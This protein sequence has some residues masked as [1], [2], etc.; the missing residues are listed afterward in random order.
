MTVGDYIF[1]SV[2]FGIT[3]LAIIAVL[4]NDK[5]PFVNC[6]AVTV[7]RLHAHY[8]FGKTFYFNHKEG[9]EVIRRALESKGYKLSYG[10]TEVRLA[11]MKKPPKLGAFKHEKEYVVQSFFG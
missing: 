4:F 3:F 1:L 9:D 6:K 8:E 2:A 5:Y 11:R 10:N 7:T